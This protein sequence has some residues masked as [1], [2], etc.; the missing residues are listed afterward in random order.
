MKVQSLGSPPLSLIPLPPFLLLSP[1]LPL[2]LPPSLTPTQNKLNGTASSALIRPGTASAV[3]ALHPPSTEEVEEEEEEWEEGL[4]C[5]RRTEG[6]GRGAGRTGWERRRKG[7]P[8]THAFTMRERWQLFLSLWPYTVPLVRRLE[9]GVG[10]REG[11]W[12]R[13]G[14]ALQL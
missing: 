4:S 11:S 6:G 12:R 7:H 5:R 14:R 2:S 1:F 9:G 10:G 13:A 3:Y 8:Q